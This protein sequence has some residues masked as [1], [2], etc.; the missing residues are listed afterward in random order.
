MFFLFVV[1][2]SSRLH[3]FRCSSGKALQHGEVKESC[4]QCDQDS[5]AACFPSDFS[6]RVVFFPRCARV[7]F[8]ETKVVAH[9]V[10]PALSQLDIH[11][12]FNE[13][14]SY[15]WYVGATRIIR[16]H[17]GTIYYGSAP[18][19]IIGLSY[20]FTLN[21]HCKLHPQWWGP[22]SPLNS[23]THLWSFSTFF[24]KTSRDLEPQVMFLGGREGSRWI[25]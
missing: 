9:L 22:T 10:R 21:T 7:L 23:L 12:W 14:T 25:W 1:S 19:K 6:L 13:E 2:L 11:I 8:K 17:F 18:E 4:D 3:T 15:T 16:N 20:L 24:F 5:T